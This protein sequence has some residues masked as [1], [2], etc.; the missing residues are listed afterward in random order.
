MWKT[1]YLDGCSTTMRC[2]ARKV[3]LYDL[4]V[5]SLRECSF[6]M[7]GLAYDKE[8]KTFWILRPSAI[9]KDVFGSN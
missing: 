4:E 7:S 8:K 2:V 6:W 3:G 5:T 1:E 9:C